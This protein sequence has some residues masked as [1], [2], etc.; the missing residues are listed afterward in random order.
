MTR[1][2]IRRI[3]PIKPESDIIRA[4]A[5]ILNREGVIV[6]PTETR[7]GMAVRA[8]RSSAFQKVFAIKG[9]SAT[10]PS[11]IF[12]KDVG[13]IGDYAVETALSRRL[14][15]KFMPGA[16]TLVLTAR[17]DL[18]NPAVHDGKIGLR[19]SS[20]KVI[21]AL[22]E[23]VEFDLTATSAN[24]AGAENPATA[25]D[26]AAVFGD[27]IDLYLDGGRLDGPVSTVV[28]CSSEKAI[29]LREGAIGSEV[30][31]DEVTV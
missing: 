29:I 12:I 15:A 19:V 10:N 2:N 22:L 28:D 21:E 1:H 30:I 20:S 14:A 27:E 5:D 13:K 23:A 4:A 7:Y 6:V 25:E 31:A 24:K 16:L 11:A 17:R 9:R 26:I 8:D 18:N 3:T